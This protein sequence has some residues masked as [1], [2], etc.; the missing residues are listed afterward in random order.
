MIV[1]QEVLA[2]SLLILGLVAPLTNHLW[3]LL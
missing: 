3:E 2:N 1:I